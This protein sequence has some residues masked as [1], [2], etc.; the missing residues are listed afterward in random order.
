[1]R[2]LFV[3]GEVTRH[4]SGLKLAWPELTYTTAPGVPGLGLGL[5]FVVGPLARSAVVC[6]KS[7][8]LSSLPIRKVLVLGFPVDFIHSRRRSYYLWFYYLIF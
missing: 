1:M 8:V 5:I 2:P 4:V 3:R 7:F 6:R